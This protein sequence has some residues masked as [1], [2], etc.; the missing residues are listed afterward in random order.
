[1]Y[2]SNIN[3][4]GTVYPPSFM[5]AC[6]TIIIVI[7]YCYILYII[8]IY[9]ILCYIVIYYCYIIVIYPHFSI[10]LQ[11][12]NNNHMVQPEIIKMSAINILPL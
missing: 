7:Y 9:Y 5:G 8:V 2:F 1:M 4:K 6:Y 12:S 11:T 10:L 3:C